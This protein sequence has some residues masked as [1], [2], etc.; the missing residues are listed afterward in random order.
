MDGIIVIL[1]M[2]RYDEL[3]RTRLAGR[4]GGRRDNE[5]DGIRAVCTKTA[6]I[7]SWDCVGRLVDAHLGYA[8]TSIN[9]APWRA[10]HGGVTLCGGDDAIHVY[11]KVVATAA[12][13]LSLLSTPDQSLKFE[14]DS[15][16]K[17]AH[18]GDVRA[19]GGRQLHTLRRRMKMTNMYK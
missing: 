18:N 2:N 14:L 19:Q 12:I 6:A 17:C 3:W 11:C 1:R 13:M 5:D 10:G 8:V 7:G 16:A 15:M 4:M 9:C